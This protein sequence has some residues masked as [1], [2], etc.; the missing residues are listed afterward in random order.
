[1][2]AYEYNKPC[3]EK[4]G[5]IKNPRKRLL[6]AHKILLGIETER[7][8]SGINKYLYMEEGGSFVSKISLQLLQP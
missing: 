1:M 5:C 8:S 7:V 6:S 3:I 4:I 2:T